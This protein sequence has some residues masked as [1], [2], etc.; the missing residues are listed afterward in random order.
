MATFAGSALRS[1]H[2]RDVRTT[3]GAVSTM[4][5]QRAL[6]SPPR[7]KTMGFLIQVEKSDYPSIQEFTG[8]SLPD[9]SRAVGF[10]DEHDL[11]HVSK[12]RNGRYPVTVVS[13]SEAGRAEFRLL[14]KEL[15]K[16]GSGS[17]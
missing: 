5:L 16:Y 8:L 15:K 14:L 1:P 11:V 7:F 2:P 13:A 12:E 4:D 17:V 9:V 10:L 6:F 3:T